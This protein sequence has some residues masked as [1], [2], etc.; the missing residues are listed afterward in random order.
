VFLITTIK[1]QLL[2]IQWKTSKE[3][4]GW[5]GKQK[6]KKIPSLK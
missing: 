2:A 5:C 1:S 4:R 6:D 3:S